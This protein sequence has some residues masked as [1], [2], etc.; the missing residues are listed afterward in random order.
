MCVSTT[1]AFQHACSAM[2][3]NGWKRASFLLRYNLQIVQEGNK[4]T[5]NDLTL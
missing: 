4:P 5:T 1:S 2:V 3:C